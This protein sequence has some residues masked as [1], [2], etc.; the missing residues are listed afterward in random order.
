MLDIFVTFY[1]WVPS[2]SANIDTQYFSFNRNTSKMLTLAGKCNWNIPSNNGIL[3]DSPIVYVP[4]NNNDIPYT[5]ILHYRENSKSGRVLQNSDG[6]TSVIIDEDID[7][8]K[9]T[10]ELEHDHWGNWK[11]FDIINSDPNY[12]SIKDKLVIKDADSESDFY[13]QVKI[14]EIF[15]N[16]KSIL[17]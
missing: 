15:N 8:R 11:Y 4:D 13:P 10:F 12:P 7:N 2:Y 3:I 17:L 16:R 9:F 14:K 1:S 6:T 5:G